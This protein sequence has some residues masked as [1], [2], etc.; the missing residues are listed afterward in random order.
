V[1]LDRELGARGR[2]PAIDV[3]RSLSRVMDAITDE[4]QRDAARRLREHLAIYEEKR[5]LVSLGAYQRGS[6]ARLDAALSRVDG[7]ESFLRQRRDER[8]PLEATRAQL[9]TVVR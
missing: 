3:L 6:D 2:W 7:I 5:D 4:A 9:A 8:V 1:I